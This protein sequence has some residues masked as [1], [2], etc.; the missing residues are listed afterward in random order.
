M[1]GKYTEAETLGKICRGNLQN[2]ARLKNEQILFESIFII[3][4]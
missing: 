3:C 4:T 2:L 1:E